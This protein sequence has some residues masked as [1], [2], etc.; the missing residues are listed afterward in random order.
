MNL[1]F[2]THR[3]FGRKEQRR[4]YS[5]VAL[6]VI[7]GLGSQVIS[8]EGCASVEG[9]RVPSIGMLRSHSSPRL[10]IAAETW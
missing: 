5:G 9:V 7:L 2:S 10:S 1:L 4:K 3:A 8:F 6:L